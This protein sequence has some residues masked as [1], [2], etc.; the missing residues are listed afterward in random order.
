MQK[1]KKCSICGLDKVIWKTV[2]RERYCKQCWSTQLVK[3]PIKQKRIPPI[4]SKLAKSHKEYNILRLK[5][6]SEHPN[7]MAS[8]PG[9]TRVSTEVHHM[10]GR[11][12]YLLDIA[13]WLSV[14]RNCHDII[15]LNPALAK[16]LNFSKSRLT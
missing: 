10:K 14:C 13:T 4:S 2:G 6:L 15:E 3:Q 12:K 9:C 5:Y 8:L 11:G 16:E 7:C 1:L